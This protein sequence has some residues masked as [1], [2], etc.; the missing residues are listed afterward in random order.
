MKILIV[1][2]LN[3]H[4]G[5]MAPFVYEQA[6]VLEKCTVYGEQCTM[7]YFGVK[8]KGIKGYL[9]Q[10]PLLKA[11][12]KE[13]HP[14]IIHA[15]YGLCGLLA[16]FQRK[17]PVVCTYHGS[18]INDPMVLPLS[19]IAMR[20]SA[21]NV[22]ISKK[23][24]DLAISNRRQV[25]GKRSS[26]IPCGINMPPKASDPR[27]TNALLSISKV[28]EPSKKHVLFA[29]A[30]D[31]AVKDASLAK[32][33]ITLLNEGTG[34]RRQDIGKVQLVELKGYNRDQVTALMYACD[35]L[36][37]TSKTEGSPQVIKEAMA[38]GLPIVSVDVG[39]VRERLTLSPFTS[40]PSPILDGCY[41][42]E[43]REPKEIAE[44][45]EK[46]L[47]FDKRTEGRIWIMKAGLTNEIV[48]EK[49]VKTYQEILKK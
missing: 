10:L 6:E 31:N 26:L 48:T 18:D 8:G 32:Q 23:T 7:E 1:G 28:L 3:N 41:V 19:K 37:M 20:L 5:K 46:S 2:S 44:L 49:L 35:A 36:L 42:A 22:F 39:D 16:N 38:C 34:D 24:M 33:V 45:L 14:D 21:W 15:H 13:F 17:V 43:S 4:G 47:A 25:I 12:I 30:F 29:G 11:K 27:I 40:H 9:K